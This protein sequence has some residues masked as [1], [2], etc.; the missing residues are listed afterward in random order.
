[1]VVSG[2]EMPEV[3]VQLC[4]AIQRGEAPNAWER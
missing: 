3:F 2:F 1:M 4:E